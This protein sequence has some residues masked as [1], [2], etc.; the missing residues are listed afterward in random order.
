M[1]FGNNAMTAGLSSRVG[2]AR[3]VVAFPG[4]GGRIDGA[5]VTYTMIA[6]Q[7]TVVGALR[8]GPSD[9]ALAL[10]GDLRDA[11]F[12]TRAERDVEGWLASHGALVVPAAA[13]TAAAGGSADALAGRRDLS[14]L[15]VRA[16][17]AVYRAQRRQGRLVVNRNLRLLYPVMPESFA[18][19]YWS[20]ALPGEF[21]ELAFAAHTRHAWDEM[22]ALGAWLRTTVDADREAAGALGVLGAV[23]P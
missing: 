20:R 9:R 8:G 2:S 14:R 3:T 23:E 22:A 19:R 12:P 5:V 10:A 15:A 11:G 17:R 1:L 21:G 16:T 6:Q 18:V 7:P 4:V 13:A